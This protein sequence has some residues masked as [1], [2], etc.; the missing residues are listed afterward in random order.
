MS[1][2]TPIIDSIDGATRRIFLRQGVSN[3]FPI[4]D[5]YHEYRNR[6]RLD[7]DGIR[8][9]NPLLR[10]EG[11]IPKGRGAFTPRYVVL[12]EGCKVVPFNETLQLN[13]L[14]DMIT[15]DPDTDSSLYDISGLTVPKPI[16]ITPSESETIQLNTAEIEFSTYNNRVTIDPINGVPGTTSPIG[17]QKNPSNNLTDALI[18]ANNNGFKDIDLMGFITANGT[19]NLD[20]FK[21]SGGSGSNN[22]VILAGCSTNYSDFEKLIVVGVFNGLSRIRD[23]ILGN[24]VLGG[25]TGVEGRIVNSIINHPD[26]I[27][28]NPSGAGTLFDNCAFTAPND[29]Q[30]VIDANGKGFGTRLCTGNILIKNFTIPEAEQVNI[31]GARVEIDNSCTNGTLTVEGNGSVVDNSNGTNVVLNL[32]S[33]SG[34]EPSVWTEEEKNLALAD[35]DTAKRQAEISALNTQKSI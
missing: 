29:P 12:L 19:H 9:Y 22:V 25:V 6:R 17:N 28:Q 31:M 15:D 23:C 7:T 16:F 4:E 1:V 27:T 11:N 21:I 2:A 3:Y 35:I 24:P 32:N 34:G 18:I 30:I 26:G 13:Q 20:G 14:G 5:L 8:K 33:V 10:A